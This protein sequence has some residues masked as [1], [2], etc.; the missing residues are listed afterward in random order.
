[1]NLQLLFYCYIIIIIVMLFK[2]IH[3]HVCPSGD[4]YLTAISCVTE[5]VGDGEGV[6]WCSVL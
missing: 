6:H 3:V 4:F 5:C 1:M 2:Y